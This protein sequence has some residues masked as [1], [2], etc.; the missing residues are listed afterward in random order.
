MVPVQGLNLNRRYIP[1]PEPEMPVTRA[2]RGRNMKFTITNSYLSLHEQ[3]VGLNS[4]QSFQ[5]TEYC[6]V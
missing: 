3:L 2:Y 1:G 5:C 4:K 6:S